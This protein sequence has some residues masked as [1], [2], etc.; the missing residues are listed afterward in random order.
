[1]A[2]NLRASHNACLYHESGQLAIGWVLVRFAP[3]RAK[4]AVSAANI[5]VFGFFSSF[6]LVDLEPG[7]PVDI[8][9]LLFGLA[10]SGVC[11]LADFYWTPWKPRR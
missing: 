7:E 10:V 3:G 4:F 6:L 9:A 5:L 8:A 1:M 11:C 2:A